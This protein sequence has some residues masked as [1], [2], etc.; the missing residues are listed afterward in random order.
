MSEITVKNLYVNPVRISFSNKEEELKWL[1]VLLDAYYLVDQGLAEAV[2]FEEKF[3]E[4]KL[5]CK[6]GCSTCC[7]AQ[8]DIPVYPLELMGLTFYAA[9]K[10]IGAEREILINQLRNYNRDQGCPFL[11]NDVC[12]AHPLRPIS[13]R[14]FMVFNKPCQE[15]EDPY[16]GRQADVLPAV[17]DYV[18]QAFFNMLPF[19]GIKSEEERS[20]IIIDKLYNKMVKVIQDCNWEK[21]AITMEEFDDRE[22]ETPE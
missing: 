16:Y 10:V 12:I 19:Y 2:T 22:G 3:R 20:K 9:E 15:G 13:C 14:L 11:I 17:Q 18:D 21:L 5:A 8:S 4:Q 7:K 1:P 6:K